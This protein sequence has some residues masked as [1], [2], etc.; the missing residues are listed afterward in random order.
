MNRYEPVL[1]TYQEAAKVLKCS[2]RTVW[3][4]VADGDLQAIR[5]GSRL[6]RIPM[7]AIEE[8]VERRLQEEGS[9]QNFTEGGSCEHNQ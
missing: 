5:V 1:L 2:P 6:V 4:L 9:G 3:T 7:V 8:F